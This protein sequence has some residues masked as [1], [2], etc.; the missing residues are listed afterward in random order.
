MCKLIHK[1]F[2]KQLKNIRLLD[3]IEGELMP[4]VSQFYGVII[5]MYYD[6]MKHH[7][8]PHLHIQYNDYK[9]IYDLNGKCIKG[10]IPNK[11]SK[12]VEAWIA[13]HTEELNTLW[14]LMQEDNEFFTIEPLK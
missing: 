3:I 5:R 6:D 4:I 7:N 10:N 1:N 11:Q 12:L 9:A 8:M 2:K 14:K 13:I